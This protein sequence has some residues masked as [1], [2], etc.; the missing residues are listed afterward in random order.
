[1]TRACHPRVCL[2][3]TT[4]VVRSVVRTRTPSSVASACAGGTSASDA[5]TSSDG[6]PPHRW[7]SSVRTLRAASACDGQLVV[8]RVADL[9]ERQPVRR[10]HGDGRVAR[11]R[12][13]H[14]AGPLRGPS[15]FADRDQAADE[16]AHHVVAERVGPDGPDEE[17][18]GF[19]LPRERQEGADRRRALAA[20]A[21]RREVV[22]PEQQRRGLV[23]RV[24]IEGA[25]PRQHVPAGERVDGLR[26]VGDPVGVAAPHR[27]EAG[28]EPVGG[29]DHAAYPDICGEHS[30]D[31]TT[32]LRDL[33]VTE[34]R[35]EVDV[36]DLAAGV[37][38][39]VGAARA[40]HR[41][42][43]QTEH[44]GQRGLEL[45]LHGPQPVLSRPA[46]EAAAVVG[47]VDPQPHARQSRTTARN[48]G[49]VPQE[50]TQRTNPAIIIVSHD[51]AAFLVDEF[52]RYAR[53]YDIR[54]ATSPSIASD[55]ATEIEA[56]GG[57]VAM[58]VAD[59]SLFPSDVPS[60]DQHNV[61]AAFHAWR[62][63]VPTA[64][65]LV[66]APWERFLEDANRLR[67]GLAKGKYDAYLLMPRGVRDEEFHTAV[68]ELLSDWGSTVAQPEVETVR[69]VS[70]QQDALTLA[71]R[72]F[73]DRMGM[74]HRAYSP[75][76]EVGAEIVARWD[77]DPDGDQRWPLVDSPYRDVFVP[78][79]VREVAATIYGRPDAIELGTVVDLC[80][81]GAGPA[82]LAAAVYGASEGLSTV[83]VEAEAVGGQAGTSS[84]IRN[85]LGFPRGISGMRLAQRARN[86]AIRF[87]TRFF[88]G[89]EVDEVTSHDDIHVVHTDGGIIKARSVVVASGVAYRK[90]RAPGVDDLTGLGI[91]YGSAMTAAREMEGYDVVVVGGGN[92]AGQAAIHL[93]RFAKSVTIMVRRAGLEQTMSSYLINEIQWNPRIVV[94]GTLRGRGSRRRRPAGVG[95]HP[96]L[97]HRRGG[98]PQRRGSLPAPGG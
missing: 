1:M 19:A 59:S 87:G 45:T 17:S 69:L 23:D 8:G 81:V 5:S 91:F 82:G 93:A 60:D 63:V 4:W 32:Q 33:D 43:R 77:G 79:S 25:A 95:R 36:G 44:G 89:W 51:N 88:T 92:S 67:A 55:V 18:A 41:D 66:V 98:P 14:L 13:Q 42:G 20:L 50:T 72:D 78:S 71:I 26:P 75:D 15:A 22:P 53:D 85:Y 28:V 94:A 97:R 11:R 86:Q 16:R 64:K 2:T 21:E 31:A 9:L 48:T 57:Q 58:Y 34:V 76:T 46:V 83:V 38:A 65:R 3:V 29:G 73:L 12:G 49:R 7:S 27:R 40:G 37:H 70:P 68:C 61:L 84:M 39:G 30:V 24:E 74:P 54:P 6:Q 90:L 35:L 62:Q 56:T 96:R 10:H 47:E 52:G 80:I